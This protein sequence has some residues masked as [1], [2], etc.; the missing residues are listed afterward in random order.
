[1]W[2]CCFRQTSKFDFDTLISLENYPSS[3][4]LENHASFKI[5]LEDKNIKFTCIKIFI[6]CR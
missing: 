6:G 2:L 3:N 1:L 4:L 5:L